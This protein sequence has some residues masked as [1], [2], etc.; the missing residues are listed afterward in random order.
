[1]KDLNL[2]LKNNLDVS[3]LHILGQSNVVYQYTLF[4][5]IQARIQSTFF[6]QV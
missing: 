6:E 2:K 1:M 4:K 3:N 5:I